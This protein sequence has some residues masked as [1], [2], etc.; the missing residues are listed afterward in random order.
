MAGVKPRTPTANLFQNPNIMKANDLD[1]FLIGQ[2][3]HQIYT[4]DVIYKKLYFNACLLQIEISIRM[5]LD[6]RIILTF[7]CTIKYWQN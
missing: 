2:V 7:P 4:A 6:N 1:V 3:M 5:K